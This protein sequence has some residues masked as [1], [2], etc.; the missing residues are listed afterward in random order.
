MAASD[1]RRNERRVR[2]EEAARMRLEGQRRRRPVDG[3]SAVE[4]ASDHGP[5]A[6]MHPVEIADGNHRAPQPVDARPVVPRDDEGLGR[7]GLGHGGAVWGGGC[8]VKVVNRP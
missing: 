5:V 1:D 6:A 4:R 8:P 2:L 7:R 3:A